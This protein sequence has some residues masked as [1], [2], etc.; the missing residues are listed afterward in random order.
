MQVQRAGRCPLQ[1]G[2]RAE[3]E[4][5]TGSA[6][7]GPVEVVVQKHRRASHTRVEV[8]ARQCQPRAPCGGALGQTRKGLFRFQA[9][10]CCCVG[11]QGLFSGKSGPRSHSPAGWKRGRVV[12]IGPWDT[13]SQKVLRMASQYGANAR[14]GALYW[15][16]PPPSFFYR[17][18]IC[19]SLSRRRRRR[20]AGGL[21]AGQQAEG[22]VS[23]GP[24]GLGA[25]GSC[26]PPT[27]GERPGLWVSPSP[28]LLCD[29]PRLFT[30]IPNRGLSR[31]EGAPLGEGAGVGVGDAAT[32]KPVY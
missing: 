3:A 30:V 23:G 28:F 13:L 27:A 18:L 15:E 29:D 9:H 6:W 24:R 20:E 1:A 32:G 31:G 26:F 11:G 8:A 17:D 16:A 21:P 10:L 19:G 2:G 7:G 5:S 14:G 4:Q 22:P 12:K 25:V